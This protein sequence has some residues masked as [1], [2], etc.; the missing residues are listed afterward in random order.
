VLANVTAHSR[1]RG[2]ACRAWCRCGST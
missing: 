1:R 2:A